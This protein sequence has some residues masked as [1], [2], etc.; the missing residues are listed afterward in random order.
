[1]DFEELCTVYEEL[2]KTS[3]GNAMREILS[4]FF[5]KSNGEDIRVIA[6]LTLGR[7]AS[8][9]DDV[10]LGFAEK[11]VIKAIA[12]ASGQSPSKVAE[13]LNKTGDIG[14]TA[15]QILQKKPKTLVP[16]GKLTIQELF[17]KLHKISQSEGK[18]S[19]ETKTIILSTLL[20]KTSPS[21]AKYV[22]RIVLGM[23]RLGVGD[24]TILD[25]LSIAYT[26]SKEK[27]EELEHAYNICP[28]V[29][30]IAQTIATKGMNAVAKIDVH[31][32]RPIKMMLA[33]RVEELDEI[34]EKISGKFSVEGKYDGERVQA[35][36]S[37]SGKIFLFSRRLENITSQFPDLV[38]YLNKN[39]KAKEFVLEGEILAI[40]EKGHPLPFQTLMQRRRKYDV[41]EYSKKV[42]IQLKA[43]DLLY[44]D[45]ESYLHKSYEER[46]EK[47]RKII[48][49]DKHLTFAERIITD[50]L[51]KVETFFQ[52]MLKEGYEGIIIKSLSGEYQAGTRG[53]NWIKW[54]KEYVQDLVDTFDLVVV[55]GFHGRG[56]RSG[57]YGALLCASYNP[58]KDL[59]ETVC[60][61]GTGFSDEVLEKIPPLFKKYLIEKKPARISVGKEMEPDVWFEPAI[62]IEV[63]AAEIT[64]SPMH[65]CADGLALRFP[66]FIRFRDDKK[67]EQATTSQ[68]IKQMSE[69]KKS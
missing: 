30:I 62:V 14:L 44:V 61:V 65:T 7:I 66:R 8:D 39:I 43:F 52:T 56:R 16:V 40:D 28:D 11:S 20:Q 31:V 57:V 32:G 26:G 48:H 50:D 55:G 69:K 42:P 37:K 5:K 15:E 60:K 13:V 47:L 34:S 9:Y 51:E 23:L 3:S 53:W 36:K 35:H 49:D 59:F 1:M 33:Q 54:K 18:G 24:M 22:T 29:G 12:Q 64:Q 68:E 6:Y 58:K 4:N 19:Q 27:K 38:I 10:E 46:T 21:A 41:E 17:E 67:A 2:E 63:L 45:E 25:A